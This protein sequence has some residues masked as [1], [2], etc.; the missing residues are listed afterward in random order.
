M[1]IAPAPTTDQPAI[2]VD[3]GITETGI[4]TILRQL[5][6]LERLVKEALR[7]G[8]DYGVIPGTDRN[9]LWKAGADNIIGAL[10]C[11]SEPHQ[12]RA[13]VDPETGFVL[14]EYEAL[15]KVNGTGVVV[16]H[17]V[18][19]CT[20]QEVKYRYRDEK[21]SCP[22]CKSTAI[23]KGKEDFG[24]GW[25]CWRKQGGCGAKYSDGD[26][27]IESQKV[28]RV[29]NPDP[30]DQTN[31]I[32]KMAEK[33]AVVDAALKLPGVARFFTQD[34]EELTGEVFTDVVS[35]APASRSGNGHQPTSNPEATA[36]AT[37]V[38]SEHGTQFD[39]QGKH[40]IHDEDG[41]LIDWCRGAA[42][43]NSK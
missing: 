16:A 29:D 38:C 26:E 10:R 14:Y 23:I 6:L 5:E 36:V 25:L 42:N 34:L 33:R 22:S 31:T 9:S 8:Q 2:P 28:G 11:H 39:K 12:T 32:M 1:T 20:N 15:I 35:E 17:G 13:V 21:R 3:F 4:Q 30:L 7:E 40:P 27:A 24:G 19:A 43:G 37:G 18:G 41:N